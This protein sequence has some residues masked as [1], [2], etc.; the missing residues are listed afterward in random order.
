M[1]NLFVPHKLSIDLMSIGFKEKT[2]ARYRGEDLYADYISGYY[3][4]WR[5]EEPFENAILAPTWDQAFEWFKK[6]HNLP[7]Y[8]R[9]IWQTE[10]NAFSY[11]WHIVEN[12]EDWNGVEHFKTYKEAQFVCLQRMIEQVKS[13]INH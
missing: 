8:I 5:F 1:E 12:K 3:T 7:S 11:Q 13:I 10:L 2:I 6:K 9:P 4:E